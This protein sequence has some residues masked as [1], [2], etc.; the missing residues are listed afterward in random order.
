M[1][2]IVDKVAKALAG[3]GAINLATADLLN[4]NVLK[5]VPIGVATTVAVL[6]IGASGVYV[7]YELYKKRI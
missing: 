5:F 2:K 6:A 4:F 3:V 7:L 1:N